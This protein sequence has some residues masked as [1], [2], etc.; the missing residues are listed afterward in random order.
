M[1]GNII[2]SCFISHYSNTFLSLYLF[3]VG[4]LYW[5]NI[6]VKTKTCSGGDGGGGFTKTYFDSSDSDDNNPTSNDG[7]DHALPE[8]VVSNDLMEIDDDPN[9]PNDSIQSSNTHSLS[10]LGES[11]VGII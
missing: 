6:Q 10:C 1:C 2:S 3:Y 8:R 5:K 11:I 7:D 9:N 4:K